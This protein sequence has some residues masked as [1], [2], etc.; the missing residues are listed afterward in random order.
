[1][2]QINDGIVNIDKEALAEENVRLATADVMT[3]LEWSLDTFQDDIGMTTAFG[4]SGLVLLHHALQIMP[5]IKIFFIDTGF[6]FRETLEF[7]E[8]IS[9]EWNLNLEVVESMTSLEEVVKKVGAEPWRVN[10]DLC[11]HYRKVEPLLRF[12]HTR[13]AWLHGLRKDQ[14]IMRAAMEVI[15][16]DG[17]GV[18]KISPLIMWTGEHVWDYIHKHNIPYHPLHDQNY[19]SIG[20]EPCTLP[21]EKGGSERDGRWPFMQKMECGIHLKPPI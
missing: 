21:V 1:M 13:K 16:L 3:I 17:R 8:R 18:L 10:A 12:I 14:S 20:C 5:D 2:I 9:N 15:E 7:S 11:C 19:P 6:H 4:T